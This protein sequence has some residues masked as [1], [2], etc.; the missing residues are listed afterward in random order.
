MNN[1]YSAYMSKLGFV[2]AKIAVPGHQEIPV[3]VNQKD[4]TCIPVQ[5]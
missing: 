5:E 2:E 1:S 4:K 3:L